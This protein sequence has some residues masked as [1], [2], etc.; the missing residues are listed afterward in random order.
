[1]SA[2]D[3]VW[4]R[5]PMEEGRKAFAYN[6]ATGKR[7]TCQPGGNLSIAVGVNL[8]TGLDDEEIEWLSKHRLQK[9][10]DRLAMFPWFQACDDKRQAVLLDVAFN[11]GVD[12]LLHFPR[13]IAAIAKQDWP[14]AANE[15]LDSQAARALPNRY[16]PLAAILRGDA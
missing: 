6:D 3:L 9:V 2:I 4:Q 15:L 16:G 14:T 13:M 8:E 12:G 1:M 10:A 7:V 5:L 11:T